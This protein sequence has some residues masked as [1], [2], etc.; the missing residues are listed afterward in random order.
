MEQSLKMATYTPA[1][2]L[3]MEDKIGKLAKGYPAS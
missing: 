2:V 3:K 1:K